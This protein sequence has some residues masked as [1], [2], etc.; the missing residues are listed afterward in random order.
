M[1][2]NGDLIVG[3]ALLIFGIAWTATVYL[4]VPTG[5]GVGPRVFPL[6]LG[7]ALSALS[8]LLLFNSVKPE[9][10][11]NRDPIHDDSES[12]KTPSLA[13]QLKILATVCV[14]IA[15]YGYLMQAIGF[16]PSTVLVVVFTLVVTLKERRPL[17]VLGMSFGLAFGAWFA[18]GKILGAYMPPGTLISIF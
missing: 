11:Q 9:A 10:S 7:I 4:T 16:V 8:A 12:G 2:R 15:V 3:I 6:W 13:L 1:T 5:Y 18:F 14:T 17:V